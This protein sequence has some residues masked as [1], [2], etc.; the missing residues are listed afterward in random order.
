MIVQSTPIFEA[1]DQLREVHLVPM[2]G[3]RGSGKTHSGIEHYMTDFEHETRC[4][5]LFAVPHDNMAFSAFYPT[6]MEVKAKYKLDSLTILQS[7]LRVR[8]KHGRII[9]CK[10]FDKPQ[11]AKTLS[12]IGRA[13]L[14]EVNLFDFA[15]FKTILGTV[16]E[17]EDWQVAMTFNPVSPDI[18]IKTKVIDSAQY[19]KDMVVIHSTCE[20]NPFLPE[21]KKHFYR[22]LTGVDYQVDYLGEYGVTTDDLIFGSRVR[23]TSF[24]PDYADFVSYGLDFS[25]GGDDPHSL[26]ELFYADQSLFIRLLYE[27]N[28]PLTTD[29]IDPETNQLLTAQGAEYAE[30]YSDLFNIIKYKATH[31]NKVLPTG[32]IGGIVGDRANAANIKRLKALGINIEGYEGTGDVVEGLRQLNTFKRIYIVMDTPFGEVCREQYQNYRCVTEKRTN[33]IKHGIPDQSCTHHAIDSGRYGNTRF[34]WL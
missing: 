12:K 17:I 2:K 3:G 18:W 1:L 28:C 7:P 19:N 4:N 10:G 22:S 31:C 23:T 25:N 30:N 33:N 29:I 34:S 21:S 14:D 9:F 8:N 27:G 24:V 13:L 32:G 16:R 15:V 11:N 6:M 20:D 26:T 5:Y